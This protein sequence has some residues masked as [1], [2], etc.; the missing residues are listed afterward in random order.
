MLL[1]Y[2]QLEC[3]NLSIT[4]STKLGSTKGQSPVIRTT[5]S[6]QDSSIACK[7]LSK[8]SSSL[9]ITDLNPKDVTYSTKREFLLLADV[10]NTIS[11]IFFA[12][13]NRFKS[14]SI[15]GFPP[16]S[17]MTLL[18]SRIELIWACTIATTFIVCTTQWL[19]SL[20]CVC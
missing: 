6:A 12:F 18:G 5:T 3:I 11:S 10:A 16:I 20:E 15:I 1:K 13:D 9:P 4:S 17:F 7:Y 8:T 19:H 2:S 14:I